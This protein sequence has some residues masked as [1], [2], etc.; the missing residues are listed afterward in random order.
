MAGGT[1][2]SSNFQRIMHSYSSKERARGLKNVPPWSN[3]L[4]ILPKQSGRY[5]RITSKDKLTQAYKAIPK[6]AI[7]PKKEGA[8]RRS[9]WSKKR[10][11]PMKKYSNKED[12]T[13]GL[14]LKQLNREEAAKLP[15]VGSRRTIRNSSNM[16]KNRKFVKKVI[17]R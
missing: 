9:N 15:N 6:Q 10:T 4:K 17:M 8:S 5:S 11:Q 2:S 3:S 16:S 1:R 14:L 7:L 13:I 12:Q